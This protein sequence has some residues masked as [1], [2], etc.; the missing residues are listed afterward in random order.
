MK[1]KRKSCAD[2]GSSAEA[3][4]GAASLRSQAPR[5]FTSSTFHAPL[6]LLGNGVVVTGFA[7]GCRVISDGAIVWQGERI[8]AAGQERQLRGTHPNARFVDARGGMIL[9]GLVNLHHHFY[10]AMARGLDAGAPMNNFAEILDRLWWRLDRALDRET[11]RV[12][13]EISAAECIRWGCATV[14]DHHS[15]PSF[16]AGSLD[17]IAEAIEKSGLSAV[18][19]YEVTDRN[20]HAQARAG[21]EE[22]LRFI[23]QQCGHSSVRGM[24]GL[25]ASFTLRDETLAEVSDR[26]PKETG[27]H[28]HVAE[29]PIDV[30]ASLKAF[31]LGPVGRLA[32]FG[33][34]NERCL[35]AHGI[36]LDA[37][38]YA[39][40]A[41]RRAVLIQN[42]E[43]NANN[44]AGVFDRSAAQA[45]GC[46]AGIG[47]DGMSSSVLRS[48]RAALLAERARH[49][50]LSKCMSP[51]PLFAN[52]KVARRFFGEPLLGE[53]APGAP[54]DI[55][56][57][58]LPASSP[59]TP[60][61]LSAHLVYGA[62]EAPVRHTIA[63]GRMLLEDFRHTTIDPF[64]IA[65]RA[66][67]L[68]PAF[69][70]RFQ[71]LN[72]GASYLGD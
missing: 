56:V 59:V 32:R 4:G 13:A 45:K 71:A 58:D 18:L 35:L 14:F 60:E 44:G 33:L 53:L 6:F 5:S 9:P 15:S 11:V 20:G 43:S 63:R 34:L 68:F 49:R 23:R 28:I 7:P 37:R 2:K 54:A 1:E 69:R 30:E 31:G 66:R 40:I 70:A 50:S 64:E 25:H 48:F 26:L 12:S 65:A 21:I 8:V 61:N 36:H 47:T 22:N 55:A 24:M 10:S 62:S 19:C 42:P 46:E 52:V 38:D 17:V 67:E 57:I 3:I 41:E 27:C 39:E 29:D 51:N 16:L 72:P